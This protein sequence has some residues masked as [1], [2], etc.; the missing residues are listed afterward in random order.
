[1]GLVYDS[2]V[3]LDAMNHT[4]IIMECI[5]TLIQDLAKT[6]QDKQEIL[7]DIADYIQKWCEGIMNGREYGIDSKVLDNELFE[8]SMFSLRIM[9]QRVI[10]LHNGNTIDDMII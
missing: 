7:C 10:S 9:V 6:H 2:S 3:N 4:T 1:M 8:V 5:M